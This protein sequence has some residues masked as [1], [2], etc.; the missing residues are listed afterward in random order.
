[1]CEMR[2]VVVE[3]VEVASVRSNGDFVTPPLGDYTF[4]VASRGHSPR[5]VLG[6]RF[7]LG[8]NLETFCEIALSSNV[9]AAGAP[10]HLSRSK[11]N[12]TSKL[13][14]ERSGRVFFAGAARL[15][16]ES[17]SSWRVRLACL[18]LIVGFC[19]FPNK[20]SP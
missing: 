1:M 15:F 6:T 8:T 13:Q 9:R 14:E 2:L 11:N 20:T 12:A 10:R 16:S 17:R 7:F 18:G 3:V 19:S 5:G 4:P